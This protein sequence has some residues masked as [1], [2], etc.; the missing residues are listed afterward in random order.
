MTNA[1]KFADFGAA[2]LTFLRE[3][4]PRKWTLYCDA[5]PDNFPIISPKNFPILTRT[6]YISN[7]Q[8]PSPWR[9]KFWTTPLTTSNTVWQVE[10]S[11]SPLSKLGSPKS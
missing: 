10:T 3:E 8:Q 1:T 6:G 11:T 4:M 9:E 5:V 7:Y 2:M